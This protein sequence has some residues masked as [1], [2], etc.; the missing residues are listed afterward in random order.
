MYYILHT[1]YYILHTTYYTLHTAYC[2][3]HTTYYI[4]HTTTYYYIHIHI[5]TSTCSCTC[6]SHKTVLD[7]IILTC[8]RKLLLEEH[9]TCS[10]VFT[11]A[12]PHNVWPAWYYQRAYQH[13]VTNAAW[14][15]QCLTMCITAAITLHHRSSRGRWV[16]WV[17][18]FLAMLSEPRRADWLPHRCVV[19]QSHREELRRALQCL[20]TER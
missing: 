18:E 10:M 8:T 19:V 17:G 3:L 6:F 4:L 9:G 1:T 2:I 15:T 7:F 5:Y 20:C 13:G 16:A 11:N 14:H 12:V